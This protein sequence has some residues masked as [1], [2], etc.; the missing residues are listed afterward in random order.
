MDDKFFKKYLKYKNKYRNLILGGAADDA[1][2]RFKERVKDAAEY[3]RFGAIA[4]DLKIAGFTL[5][6]LKA[7]G[8]EAEELKEAEFSAKELKEA[9]FTAAQL[10]EVGFTAEEL[11]KIG[12]K[13]IDLIKSNKETD[14]TLY[15]AQLNKYLK[16]PNGYNDKEI[17]EGLKEARKNLSVDDLKAMGFCPTAFSWDLTKTYSG[18]ACVPN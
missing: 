12:F 17:M 6:E 1:T 4:A 10:K 15:D 9:G 8:F 3:L 11:K 16:S 7:A 5:A 14:R 13:V 18:K 2:R